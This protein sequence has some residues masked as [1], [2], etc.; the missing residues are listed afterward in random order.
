MKYYQ[1]AG[2]PLKTVTS[3][4]L[5]KVEVLAHVCGYQIPSPTINSQALD[6]RTSN[7]HNMAD[8]LKE[9][10]ITAVQIEALVGHTSLE[11]GVT[12]C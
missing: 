2:G 5:A 7:T 3:R 11:I 8:V 4:D 12:A 6:S 10:P 9:T 1:D